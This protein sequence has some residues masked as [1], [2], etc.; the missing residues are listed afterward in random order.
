LIDQLAT[1]SSNNTNVLE[2]TSITQK[3]E[4]A[5]LTFKFG[6]KKIKIRLKQIEGEWISRTISI[7]SKNSIDIHISDNL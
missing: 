2:L 7:K 5:K 1:P 3:G 4:K 6:N